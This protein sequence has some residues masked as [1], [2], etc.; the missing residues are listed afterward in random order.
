MFLYMDA[1][2][3]YREGGFAGW[4]KTARKKAGYTQQGLADASG[5]SKSY[6]SQLEG[7]KDHPLTGK[8]V[9]PSREVVE[10]IADGLNCDI[11]EALGAAGYARL[12]GIGEKWAPSHNDFTR[13]P[14]PPDEY[15]AF[16][17][18]DDPVVQALASGLDA[19]GIAEASK[20]VVDATRETLAEFVKKRNAARVVGAKAE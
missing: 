12:Q 2:E 11:D 15:D 14:D 19:E 16:D 7:G 20:A 17:L 4:L 6:I 5:L 3:T 1:T 13:E 10:K 9:E 18:S 8:P